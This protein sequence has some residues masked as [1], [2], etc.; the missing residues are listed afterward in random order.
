[1]ELLPDSRLRNKPVT[2]IRLLYRNPRQTNL[3]C[4]KN[5]LQKARPFW[6]WKPVEVTSAL[7]V[8]EIDFFIPENPIYKGFLL[9]RTGTGIFQ[10]VLDILD[11]CDMYLNGLKRITPGYGVE[12]FRVFFKNLR[13][14]CV[15]L[16]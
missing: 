11:M 13:R 9:K 2:L 5:S 7:R 1:M 10:S 3:I 12:N 14:I 4:E 8:H 6:E 15:I 16:L